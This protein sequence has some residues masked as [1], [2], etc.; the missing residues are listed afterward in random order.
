MADHQIAP[1]L[2]FK[3]LRRD[4]YRCRYCGRGASNVELHVDHVVARARGGSDDLANLKTA[5]AECNRAKQDMDG[6]SVEELV[7]AILARHAEDL[8]YLHE[9][10]AQIPDEGRV[11]VPQWASLSGYLECHGIGAATP[12]VRRAYA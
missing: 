8:H 1:S 6:R 7:Q 9:S 12:G 10:Y 3:V 5:C 2:R 11:L 4:N